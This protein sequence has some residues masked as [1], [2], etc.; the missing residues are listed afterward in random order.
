M[1]FA[2]SLHCVG[3]CSPLAMAVTNMTPSIFLNKFLYNSGRIM[4]YSFFGAIVSVVGVVFPL[5][6][7]QN[8]LSLTLGV[9][10]L[11]IG[12][13]G[14]RNVNLP[15]ITK[16]LQSVSTILKKQFGHFLQRKSYGSILVLGML[17]GML[18]CGLTF[19]ALTFC[20]TLEGPIHGFTFMMLF[21]AGTLPAMFGLPVVIN[22]L[23]NKL[24]WNLGGVTTTLLIASGGLLIAR[25]FLVTYT[26]AHSISE[27]V[28]ILLC[29]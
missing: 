10:L 3:M 25:V 9:T 21:G 22:A 14:I 24:N 18:P 16:G 17:N 5:A 28:D 15:L 20:L 27:G 2:G 1:G 29:R 6:G 23:V 11:I 12:I 8:L 4:M 19:I 7:F 13:A 26:H